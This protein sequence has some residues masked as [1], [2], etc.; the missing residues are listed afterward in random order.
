MSG[1]SR[2]PH[3]RA[4]RT[5]LTCDL[6]LVHRARQR[7]DGAD[8]HRLN[9]VLALYC[10]AALVHMVGNRQV[11]GHV[12]LGS[13]SGIAYS[14]RG[15]SPLHGVAANDTIWSL[16]AS[17]IQ[18]P[19]VRRRVPSEVNPGGRAAIRR[20]ELLL[21]SESSDPEARTG[22]FPAGRLHVPSTGLGTRPTG[23]SSPGAVPTSL[24][25][26]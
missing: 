17:A 8:V 26:R 23:S 12:W 15:N 11:P 2:R 6:A 10:E 21:C 19:R 5:D 3:W 9:N 22:E 7:C 25:V 13:S 4:A 16:G 18:R 14:S 24:A 20:T 1:P